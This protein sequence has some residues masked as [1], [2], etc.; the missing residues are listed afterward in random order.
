MAS[1]TETEA[2]RHEEP[3]DPS[4]D[5]STSAS[6]SS[7][8]SPDS[9]IADDVGSIVHLGV[10][11]WVMFAFLVGAF[12][13]FWLLKNVIIAVWD[14]FDE[15]RPAVASA[16]AAAIALGVAFLSYQRPN[17]H[18]F[19]HDVATEYA[20]VTWPSR[21]EAWSHTAVVIVVSLIATGILFGLDFSWSALTNLLYR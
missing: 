8:L 6:Q 10:E 16:V 2:P 14:R 7:D 11:R 15:P 5:S 18:G 1:A 13:A 3:T 20:K 9:Q 4:G 12:V 19:A 17:V 21:E